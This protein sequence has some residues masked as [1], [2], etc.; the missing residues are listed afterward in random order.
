MP[1]PEHFIPLLYL[2]GLADAEGEAAEVLARG[3]AMGSVSMT[4]YGVGADIAP[5]EG[6]SAARLPEGVPPDQTNM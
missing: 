2:A 1:T 4:C 6:A 3:H 5:A